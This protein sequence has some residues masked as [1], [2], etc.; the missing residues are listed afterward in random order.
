MILFHAKPIDKPVEYQF[1][2]VFHS[3]DKLAPFVL[4]GSRTRINESLISC[5]YYYNHNI[6]YLYGKNKHETDRYVNSMCPD[7]LV[8]FTHG[9]VIV[10]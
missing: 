6:T 9:H 1:V 7:M 2:C 8:M 4:S 5:R 10:S 3:V